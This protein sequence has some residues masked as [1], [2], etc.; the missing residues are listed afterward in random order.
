LSKALDMEAKFKGLFVSANQGSVESYRLF[1]SQLTPFLRRY[2]RR[3]LNAHTAEVEDLTQEVL[4]ALHRQRHTFDA[5]YPLTAW[6]HGIARYKLVDHCK[7]C[8]RDPEFIDSD[9]VADELTHDPHARN[10]ACRDL[11]VMLRDLP[12]PQRQVIELV[13]LQGRSLKEVSAMTGHT[14]S[15]VKVNI[16]RGLKELNRIWGEKAT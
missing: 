4:W 2:F 5:R 12:D 3:H 1:L 13:K 8:A 11:Q 16:H 10:E 14:E 6:V 9:L 15:W 7:R